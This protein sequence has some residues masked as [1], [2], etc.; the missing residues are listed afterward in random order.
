MSLPWA[1]ITFCRFSTTEATSCAQLVPAP[2]QPAIRTAPQAHLTKYRIAHPSPSAFGFVAAADSRAARRK[3]LRRQDVLLKSGSGDRLLDMGLDARPLPQAVIPG[4]QI[5]EFGPLD[6]EGEPAVDLGAEHDLGEAQLGPGEIGPVLQLVIDDGPGGQ[7]P[8]T[9]SLDRGRIARL[10]LGAN[11]AEQ[12]LAHRAADHRKLPVH[13]P[14][15]MRARGGIA[16]VKTLAVSGSGE[17][18]ADRV[19]F[20]HDQVAVLDRRDEAVWVEAQIFGVAIAAERSADIEP[21]ER[22]VE[23]GAAPQHLLHVGRARASPD[24]Q[25]RPPPRRWSFAIGASVP[26]RAHP[27]QRQGPCIIGRCIMDAR[28]AAIAT[29]IGPPYIPPAP[30]FLLL[31]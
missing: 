8:P 18:A 29:P 5:A 14:L 16:G 24:L 9:R 23:L 17:I 28:R 1:F 2:T 25:H 21:L 19:R 6:R 11:Q 20:P 13:P 15:D 27:P 3:Q 22:D 31:P 10:G 30:A 4:A 26:R 12:Q 7:R